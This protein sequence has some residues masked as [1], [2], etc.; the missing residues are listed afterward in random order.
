METKINQHSAKILFNN[1]VELFGEY[2]DKSEALIED[3]SDL[4]QFEKFFIET[5]TFKVGVYKIRFNELFDSWQVSH[6][7]AGVFDFKKIDDAIDF[8]DKG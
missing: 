3:Y 7:E 5:D 4:D 8:A 2:G 1:Q 6:D